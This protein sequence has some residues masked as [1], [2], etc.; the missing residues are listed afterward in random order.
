MCTHAH[1]NRAAG[2]GQGGSVW[3]RLRDWLQDVGR[4]GRRRPLPQTRQPRCPSDTRTR[5]STPAP[6]PPAPTRGSDPSPQQFAR[7]QTRAQGFLEP[8]TGGETPR[9]KPGAG[10]LECASGSRRD[11]RSLPGPPAG[12]GLRLCLRLRGSAKGSAGA[13]HPSHRLVPLSPPARNFHVASPLHG[14]GHADPHQ[15]GKRR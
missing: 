7:S 13:E 6:A 10:S 1:A 15:A 14:G 9:P 8:Q 11:P 3:G 5:R 2:Q 4:A 12:G